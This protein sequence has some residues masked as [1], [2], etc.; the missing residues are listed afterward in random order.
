MSFDNGGKKGDLEKGKKIK[1]KVTDNWKLSTQKVQ[2][3]KRIV[4][5]VGF[6]TESLSDSQIKYSGP[7]QLLYRKFPAS[8]WGEDGED[9]QDVSESLSLMALDLSDYNPTHRELERAKEDAPDSISLKI[10]DNK[11]DSKPRELKW[12]HPAEFPFKY[13]DEQVYYC[14]AMQILDSKKNQI[15]HRPNFRDKPYSIKMSFLEGKKGKEEW[16]HKDIIH[17]NQ[18]YARGRGGDDGFWEQ[19]KPTKQNVGKLFYTLWGL[20]FE[21]PTSKMKIEVIDND[22]GKVVLKME[23]DIKLTLPEVHHAVFE[24]DEWDAKTF[25]LGETHYI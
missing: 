11:E 24:S 23:K 4:E 2:K 22:L 25:R 17:H 5:I 13:K 21:H 3:T 12:D 18:M 16:W 14:V 7:A 15:F 6:Q 10:Y 9:I 1:I 20:N 19:S 8:M